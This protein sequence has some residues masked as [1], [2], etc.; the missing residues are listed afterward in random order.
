LNVTGN[1]VTGGGSGDDIDVNQ[2]PITA[3]VIQGIAPD[4][5]TTSGQVEA[6]LQSTN[7]LART[8]PNAVVSNPAGIAAG[9]AC[10]L[11]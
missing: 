7:T 10:A 11:P 3:M 1:S 4:P 5:S 9:P 8:Q 6:H 2:G